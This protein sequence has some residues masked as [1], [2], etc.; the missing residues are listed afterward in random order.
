MIKE[1]HGATTL[2]SYRSQ[3]HG[4]PSTRGNR[5]QRSENKT[6][7]KDP[8]LGIRNSKET[9]SNTDARRKPRRCS[10]IR[11]TSQDIVYSQCR[12]ECSSRIRGRE[13]DRGRW[14]IES[15]RDHRVFECTSARLGTRNCFDI[16]RAHERE[17]D[18]CGNS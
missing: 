12:R 13:R 8:R 14:R 4:A 17:R 18:R 9:G 2:R 1:W 15:H 7:L 5:K 3:F 16:G 6:S 10:Q 11:E